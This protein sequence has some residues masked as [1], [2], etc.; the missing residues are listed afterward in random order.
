MNQGGGGHFFF[1]H[2][3]I[4]QDGFFV[5]PEKGN[6]VILCKHIGMYVVVSKNDSSLEMRT[7]ISEGFACQCG[8]FFLSCS[9]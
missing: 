2:G 5:L 8:G 9:S 1:N 6:K 7:F 4:S 3:G